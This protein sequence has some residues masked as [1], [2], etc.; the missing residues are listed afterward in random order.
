[1]EHIKTIETRELCEA[2]RVKK[3]KSGDNVVLTGGLINGQPGNT[4]MIKLETVK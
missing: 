1:M 4:N 3:L 2:K